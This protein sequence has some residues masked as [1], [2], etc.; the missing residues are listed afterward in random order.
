MA[1]TVKTNKG[2]ELP[3]TNL[4]GKDYLMV[5]YRLQWLTEDVPSYTIN[6][7]FLLVTED[8][9][10][11]KAKVTI[12]NENGA[13]VKAAEATKRET[14]KDF[15]DHTEKAETS[16]IGR[17]L[18][19]LGFGTQH[20]IA[21]LDEGDRIVDSPV[22]N[23]R[24]ESRAAVASAPIATVAAPSVAPAASA[25]STSQAA[26]SVVTNGLAKKGGFGVKKAIIET[27]TQSN[28]NSSDDGWS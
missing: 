8:Q 9:T 11:C 20:A 5:A 10:I 13:V 23:V 16:A 4:K 14:K 19:M 3:L 25:T 22:V 12:F 6:T 15:P 27:N 24:S 26:A 1:K 2:T 7:E 17:A 21:D 18:A 28:N